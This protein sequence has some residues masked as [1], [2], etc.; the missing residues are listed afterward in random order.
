MGLNWSDLRASNGSQREG[1]EELCSQ[2]ARLETPT[3]AEFVR[4]GN[5]DSGVE[6]FCTHE[7][8]REW[9]WQAK[10]FREAL[11]EAQW[12]QLDRAV[13]AALDG[14]PG[15]ARYYVC[16]PRDRA[17]GRRA[18]VVTE[19][20]KW[21]RR[22]STWKGWAHDR[23][24]D[25]EFVWWGSSELTGLLSRDS[26]VG[27]VRYW[28]GTGG[29]FSH[30]WLDEQLKRAI[31]VAG[32]RYTRKIHVDVPIAQDFEAFG[33][34]EAAAARVS[35]LAKSVRQAPSYTLRR[36]ADEKSPDAIAGLED[37]VA[38]LDA[39][40]AELYGMRC[41]AHQPWPLSEIVSNIDEVDERLSEFLTPLFEMAEALDGQEQPEEAG[42]RRHSNPYSDAAREVRAVRQVLWEAS[43][44]LMGLAQVVNSDLLIVKGKAGSGKTHLLC[45]VAARRLGEKYPTVVLMGQE[46]TTREPPWIQARTQLDLTNLSAEQFVGALEAAAQAADTRALFMIDA[47]N[48]GEGHA[49]WQPHLAGFLSRLRASP[50]IGV[51]LSVRSPFVD[52]VVPRPVR[53]AAHEVTHHGFADDPYVALERFC[54]FYDLDFPATPLLRAEFGNPLF[55]KTLCEGLH[56][57]GEHAI[58]VGTEGVSTVFGRYLGTVDSALARELD[59]DPQDRIVAKALDA[60]ASELAECAVR[61][62]PRNKA[63]ELVDPLAPS[64][65]FGRSLYRALVGA[66]LL[67]EA[68]GSRHD[69]EWTVSFGYEWFADHLI[70]K[71]LIEHYNDAD[72]LALALTANDVDTDAASWDPWNA[73]L[74]ALSILL[75]ELRGIELPTALASH[76]TDR[77]VMSALLSGLPWRDPTRIGRGGQDLI[78]DLLDG[79]FRSSTVD[80]FDALMVCAV[81]P[82]HPLGSEFLDEYLRRLKMPDRDAVWSRYLYRAYGNKGPLD[83]L[84]DWTE[85]HP[86]RVAALDDETAEACA[87]VLAWCLTASHRFVRDR[88]TKGLVAVLTNRIALTRDLVERFDDVDDPYVRERVMAAAYG[89][90]MRSTDAPALV[91]LAETVYRLIFADGAPPPHILL[92]DYA[93]GVIERAQH[94][95]ASLSVVGSLVEPPY[96]SDWP[97]IPDDSEMEALDPPISEDQPKLTRIQRAQRSIAFSV[98][99]WDFGRYVIG[100]NSASTSYEWLSVPTT[101]PAWQSPEQR[102]AAFKCSLNSGLK[103]TFDALWARTRNTEPLAAL[104]QAVLDADDDLAIPLAPAQPDIDPQLESQFE[105]GLSEEQQIAYGQIMAARDAPE[106][107]LSLE[108][109]QRYVVWRAFDL[110][111]TVERFGDLDSGISSSSISARSN[112]RKPERMG[113]K[114]QWIGYHEI[115]AHVSD[116]YQYRSRYSDEVPQGEYQGAWQLSVRDIDPSSVVAPASSLREQPGTSTR[117]WNRDAPVAPADDVDDMQWL[118]RESDIPDR[119]QQMRFIEPASGSA[120]V[121]LQ[122]MDVWQSSPPAGYDRHEVD[123]REIW[124]YACGYLI[125]AA[126]VE[127]FLAWSEAVDFSGRWMPEPP[128]AY[129]MFFGELGWSS[130]SRGLLGDSLGARQ[131]EPRDGPEC[132]IALQSAAFECRANSGQYDCSLAHGQEFYRPNPRLADTLGL[133]WTGYGADFVDASGALAAFDSAA[134]DDSH[135]ALLMREDCLASFLNE[136]RSALVWAT[137]G[138]KQVIKPRHRQDPWVGFLRLTDA[139]VY[140]AGRLRGHRTTQLEIVDRDR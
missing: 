7:D 72:E 36:L 51:V 14:H 10:F 15:L 6:C 44:A 58:P 111:W 76:E 56:S 135:G 93:R 46:F 118:R 38:S 140:E 109:I 129:D 115:L 22:L 89:V 99:L 28:F 83:R 88:A 53:E 61:W 37:V 85:K 77:G 127:E 34:T 32:P 122:G 49:I 62:L 112:T 40:V 12:R 1:F 55:L 121:K 104:L 17:D 105:A 134:H 65:G 35:E 63:R 71:R 108:L 50:W 124:L 101:E 19:M 106:P 119:D 123:Q 136:T 92:R 66:G 69:E 20:Q 126:E 27:R 137:I 86:H 57:R 87:V 9:G 11:G 45:D 132:P 128:G 114:Y 67:L 74:E 90:A 110:G 2:L 41:A 78:V 138:E 102:A 95:G 100:T 80:V 139:V 70:A 120:W 73:P 47:I 82:H 97:H 117:W 13:E 131:P 125:D 54:E 18:G 26:Q 3:N 30:E 133:R 60:V 59:Y 84:L 29:Q 107:R 113:K 79:G 8:G 24:M 23:Q 75:P 31:D 98:M 130:A 52:Y 64:S 96:R 5:P 91:P 103:E 25:V 81:V 42:S 16:V 33:R 94:L 68:P 21:E 43:A 48:E 4:K 39:V 116:H